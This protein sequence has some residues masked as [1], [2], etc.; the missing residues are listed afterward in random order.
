MQAEA[1]LHQLWL[2]GAFQGITTDEGYFAR[3]DETTHSIED[4]AT[5]RLRVRVGY[6]PVKPAE[7]IVRTVTL[8]L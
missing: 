6:A 8:N 3:C 5:G 7:F 1:I 2:S 4:I